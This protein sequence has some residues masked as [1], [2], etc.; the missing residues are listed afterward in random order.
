MTLGE[1]F[2]TAFIDLLFNKLTSTEFLHFVRQEGLHTKLKK[3]KK[4]L[5]IIQAV[6]SDAEE[7]QITEST[8]KLWLEDLR[9]LAYD[10][11]DLLDELATEALQRKLVATMTRAERALIPACLPISFN[12]STLMFG[13]RMKSKMEEIINR[14]KE[15]AAR[16]IDLGLREN[17]GGRCYVRGRLP[18]T[19]L[20]DES[21]VYGRGEEKRAILNRLLNDEA[22]ENEIGVIPIVGMPGFGKTTLAKL[23]YND[24]QVENHFDPRVWISVTYDFDVVRVTKTILQSIT[25]S[26]QDVDDLKLLQVSLKEKL[27]G[28][29]FLMVLDD[30]WEEDYATWDL[31]HSPLRAGAAGSKLIVT[32][33]SQRVVSV[34]GG[35]VSSPLTLQELLDDD[36]L[37]ILTHN[38]LGTRNFDN[39]PTLQVIG[40]KIVRKCKGLPLAAK[41]LGGLL[42]TKPSC[43]EWAEI[44]GSNIWDLPEKECSILPALKLSYHHLPPH[45]KQCFTCCSVFPKGYEFGKSELIL[46]WMAEGLLE[47][48]SGNKQMEDLGREYFCEIL[49]RS[50]FQPSS[51][52]ESKFTMHDL[53]NDLAQSVAAGICFNSEDQ[54]ENNVRHAISEKVRHSSFT[55]HM[56]GVSE[57][58]EP[59]RRAKY[60]RTFLALPI[61]ASYIN[62]GCYI[63]SKVLHDLL[64]EMRC[65]RVLS[66]SGYHISE[67][68]NSLGDLKHLRYL[69]FSNTSIKSLPDSVSNL[70]NLQTLILHGCKSLSKLPMGIG[71]FINLRHLDLVDT[72]R[73][74]EMPSQIGKLGSL[75]TLSKFIVSKGSGL[76][77]RN[78]GNLSQLQGKLSILKL[79]N[80]ANMEEVTDAN[81]KSKHKIQDLT[82]EWSD[83][84]CT[85]DED[86]LVLEML[87]PHENLKKLTIESYRGSKFPFWIGHPSF[88]S[89]VEL[90]L[91]NCRN[92][93]GLP[94]LGRLPSLKVLQIS[95][96]DEV[97]RVDDRFYGK[98][99]TSFRPFPSL[100]SL[101][102]EDMPNWEFW[103]PFSNRDA[104]V[105]QTI[106][107]CLVELNIWKCPKL[108]FELI[109]P[110]LPSFATLDVP[111]RPDILPHVQFPFLRELNITDVT[112]WMCGLHINDLRS[113]FA[114]TKL[115]VARIPEL[116]SI[117]ERMP[118]EL[119]YL[120]ISDCA[121]L[122][123]L[124]NGL[125]RHKSLKEL[126]IG[127]CPRLVSFP[128]TGLPPMLRILV[129]D[130]CEG[131]K[132]LPDGGYDSSSHFL[133][134]LEVRNCPSLVCFPDVLPSTLK[135]L[136]IES[137]TALKALPDAI[138]QASSS[139][140]SGSTRS[141]SH[142]EILKI[143]GCPSLKG[144]PP[145]NFP[146]SLKYLEI[147]NCELLEPIS[148]Q[149]LC[150][151]AALEY[152]QMWNYPNLRTL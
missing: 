41:A 94:S 134:R 63:S 132:L 71:N 5:L 21:R 81:L 95:G 25:S 20:V 127:H 17:T 126:R 93:R 96:M 107:P 138:M 53:I 75:Q 38:A 47:Q 143:K 40:E 69:N 120:E 110:C 98:V 80:I 114:L 64:M 16:K 3:L 65:L 46:I 86:S 54:P 139:S 68:P 1:I 59:L 79:Q 104:A 87:E 150:N 89:M 33:R 19:S 29:K 4:T 13:A 55:R 115:T 137:C 106:F 122:E 151:N 32:T 57:K 27:G 142:L 146:S 152:L 67:L 51:S 30:V 145:G 92:C 28:K 37:P 140:G 78:L 117:G 119:E 34:I 130:G 12:P 24:D 58:F 109:H 15:I 100:E 136:A 123:K 18:T 48:P 124:P 99:S 101:T 62:S 72:D 97:R 6:L 36:C 74:H 88:S 83:N 141:I 111:E 90:N 70:C 8:V 82:M 22:S 43:E 31:F 9:D 102:F 91:K 2:L 26:F 108:I 112:G 118:L 39:H 44:L 144:I 149:L 103:F 66:L 45:L 35:P 133:E 7:K 77:I 84:L 121:R 50:L 113:L 85:A 42:R 76:R 125:H 23:A 52:S 116:V 129:L 11:D 73:L 105:L 131:L 148:G 14:V 56:Y 135:Q 49:S 60:L 10:M 61:H 147:W 128:E